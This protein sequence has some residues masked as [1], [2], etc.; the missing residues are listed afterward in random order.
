MGVGDQT[1]T[2]T[3]ALLTW[4]LKDG[5]GMIG[6]IVFAWKL[7]TRLD[8]DAKT[9]RL[10]ADVLNDLGVFLE[11]LAP[12]SSSKQWFAFWAC[13]A[14]LSRSLC[15]V[16]GGATRA[17][18]TQ[19]FA[20]K[21][22]MADVSAKDG[23]QETI[24]NLVAMIIGTYVATSLIPPPGTSHHES[25]FWFANGLLPIDPHVFWTWTTFLIFTILHLYCN[26]CAV[27]NVVL[28]TLNRERCGVLMAGHV[29]GVAMAKHD[30]GRL[31]KG[32]DGF[33]GMDL[34][35]MTPFEVSKVEKILGTERR[36][37]I[38]MGCS[39]IDEMRRNDDRHGLGL[40]HETWST[41]LELF[42]P[43]KY[44]ALARVVK[45]EVRDIRIFFHPD[46]S[47]IDVLK[48]YYHATV[49]QVEGWE[50][51]GRLQTNP[52]DSQ[53]HGGK[54]GTSQRD[55]RGKMEDIIALHRW[56]LEITNQPQG[57]HDFWRKLSN[58]KME[59]KRIGHRGGDKVWSEY[60]GGFIRQAGL[61]R[62]E[63]KEDEDCFVRW[64]VDD[65]VGVLLNVGAVRA[66]WAKAKSG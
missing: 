19:H 43:E 26:Y 10:A 28:N 13:A 65:R 40:D 23:S 39:L 5:T 34:Q 56:A 21:D 6:H 4:V 46:A 32:Q 51:L 47:H 16:A 3:S 62:T 53:H 63:F 55:W 8:S 41:I 30:Q 45:N 60:P 15:G 31:N 2:T 18:L 7:S 1:A 50:K 37:H 36:P 17:A 58:V 66:I 52:S 29:R 14:N 27:C 38:Q 11:L 57:F 48:A 25:I 22:N 61:W 9:W 35:L 64:M 24:V 20:K 49:L 12:L 42:A 59:P 44:L 54:G 33:C